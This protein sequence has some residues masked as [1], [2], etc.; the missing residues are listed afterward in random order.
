M[1]KGK[2]TDRERKVKDKSDQKVS[3]LFDLKERKRCLDILYL[4]GV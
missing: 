4:F 2:V 1:L 3:S